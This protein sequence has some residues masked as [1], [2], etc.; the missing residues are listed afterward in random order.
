MAEISRK[1]ATITL[2][3]DRNS[4]FGGFVA[5]RLDELH[6]AFLDQQASEI[7]INPEDE[8]DPGNPG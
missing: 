2:A 6:A 5:S 1:G 4:S 7:R 3:I 8:K